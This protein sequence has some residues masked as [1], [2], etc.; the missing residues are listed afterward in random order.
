[1]RQWL[2]TSAFVVAVV[3]LWAVNRSVTVVARESGT[4]AAP[5]GGMR[6]TFQSCGYRAVGLNVSCTNG[7]SGASKALLLETTD[8]SAASC[9]AKLVSA[10]SQVGYRSEQQGDTATIYGSGIVVRAVGPVFTK[11]DF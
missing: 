7:Q 4:P 1:M 6:I 9:A 3:A 5:A 10:C 11:T 8:T 2:V